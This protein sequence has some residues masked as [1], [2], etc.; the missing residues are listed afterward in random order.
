MLA[1]PHLN[2]FALSSAGYHS[3]PLLPHLSGF[4]YEHLVHYTLRE[5]SEMSG[6]APHPGQ[7]LC[8]SGHLRHWTKGF[9]QAQPMGALEA[10]GQTHLT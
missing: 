1:S 9:R 4:V 3:V 10:S 6:A 5:A 7:F 8:L 2:T